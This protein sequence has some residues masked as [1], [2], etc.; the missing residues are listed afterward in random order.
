M[1]PG[2]RTAYPRI[3]RK[4][5]GLN[6]ATRGGAPSRNCDWAQDRPDFQAPFDPPFTSFSAGMFLDGGA[7]APMSG[8]SLRGGYAGL[9]RDPETVGRAYV[10]KYNIKQ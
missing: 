8:S 5:S 4:G 9:G 2:P 6:P 10:E 3:V 7:T 1:T